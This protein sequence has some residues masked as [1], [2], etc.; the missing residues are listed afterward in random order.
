MLNK[1]FSLYYKIILFFLILFGLKY[2]FLQAFIKN[3]NFP[4][5]KL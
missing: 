3:L 1:L 4:A 5:K 2:V